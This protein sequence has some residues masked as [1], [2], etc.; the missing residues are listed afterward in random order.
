MLALRYSL[1]DL[2]LSGLLAAHGGFDL[3]RPSRPRKAWGVMACHPMEWNFKVIGFSPSWKFHH[4]LKL[5][6]H[7]LRC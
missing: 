2:G 3:A 5:H 7:T 6:G 1:F 4:A